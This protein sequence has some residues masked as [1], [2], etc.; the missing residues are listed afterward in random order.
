ME[1]GDVRELPLFP[2]GM[3]LNPGGSAP[4]HIFEMR[5]RLLFN[6]IQDRDNKFGIIFYNKENNL[7]GRVG[8]AALVRFHSTTDRRGGRCF[9]GDE[10]V[11]VV[12]YV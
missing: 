4:L 10:S 11:S 12:A 5:Y 2:L 6:R 1:S 9:R 3:V 7:I 8:C